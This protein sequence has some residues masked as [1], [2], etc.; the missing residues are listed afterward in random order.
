MRASRRP[1]TSAPRLT[2]RCSGCRPTTSTSTTRTRTTRHSA[3]GDARRPRRALSRRARSGTSRPPTTTAPRLAEALEVSGRD[4]LAALRGAC[5]RT[6]TS[7]SAAT[8]A[9]CATSAPAR[10]W[11]ACRISR[12]RGASSPAS[13]ARGP[14]TSTAREPAGP[15]PTSTTAARAC[16]P[17]STRSPPPQGHAGAA[18]AIAWLAAQPTVTAPIASARSTEQLAELPGG[19]AAPSSPRTSWRGRRGRPGRELHLT[20]VA[21]V[22]CGSAQL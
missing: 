15:A 16:S 1:T 9:R 7:S 20:R 11:A 10:A 17:R 8:K 6:T 4:G 19:G 2:G 14:A 3:R 22:A 21:L 5:S 18:V 12:W 13:T